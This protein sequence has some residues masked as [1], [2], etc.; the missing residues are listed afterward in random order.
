MKHRILTA[1]CMAICLA[2][3][4]QAMAG[5]GPAT[6]GHLDQSVTDDNV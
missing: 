6:H 2:T 3:S 5:L 4:A 1:A